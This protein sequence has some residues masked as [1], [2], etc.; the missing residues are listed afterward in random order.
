LAG[1]QKKCSLAWPFLD[2]VCAYRSCRKHGEQGESFV[3]R[4]LTFVLW[5]TLLGAACSSE[6]PTASSRDAVTTT[7]ATAAATATA[8]A[9]AGGSA[10]AAAAG[11]ASAQGSLPQG[12]SRLQPTT[13]MDTSGFEKPVVAFSALAPAG[14]RAQG[15]VAWSAGSPCLM[16]DYNLGWTLTAPDGI[17]AVAFVV[18]PKWSI[19]K[20]FLQY[21][22][23]PPGPCEGPDW[24]TVQQYLEA[25]VRQAS[26]EARI[27][28]YQ[29]RPDLVREY[30]AMN[31]PIPLPPSDLVKFEQRTEAGQVL[32]AH[33]V[34]GRDVREMIVA[35]VI[36]AE[37]R[38]MD[39]MNPGRVGLVLRD[40]IPLTVIYARAPAGELNVLLPGVIA[41]SMRPSADWSRRVFLFNMEKQRAAFEA[42]MRRGQYSAEQLRQMREAND[43]A[44]ADRT[45]AQAQRDRNYDL[46]VI[47]G[48]KNQREFVE[49]IRGVETYHEPVD[50]GVV[51]LDNTYDHAWRVRDGSYLLTNDPNFRPGLVGLEGQELRKVD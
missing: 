33:A 16:S 11:T 36:F 50:G 41:K 44:V 6:S 20:S 27:L 40:G 3:R 21:D 8:T 46:G 30:E 26:P 23:G 10:A 7:A 13:I 25:L 12:V 39:V 34:N 14:W 45:A 5:A 2:P 29:P 19:V 28:D 51:Q 32:F 17:S 42:M 31:K 24:T 38:T 47:A 18:K 4:P 9:T 49:S 37:T 22:R 43:R 48:E 15:G 35:T 1:S